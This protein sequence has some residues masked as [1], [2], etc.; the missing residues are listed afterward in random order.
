M[1]P[2]QVITIARNKLNAISDNFWSDEELYNYL[3]MKE[4]ELAQLANTIE[5]RYTADS[6]ASQIE[7][8]YPTNTISVY[9]VEYSSVKL[10]KIDQRQYDS[11][12]SD[13]STVVTG[14]PLYYYI[15]DRIIFLHPAP[16]TAITSAIRMYS[17]D[18]PNVHTA[19]S[20]FQTPLEY[21][22]ALI[23]GVAMEM[24]PKE[25]GHPN[26]LYFERIWEGEKQRV[27]RAE[28]TR[29][30]G[31]KFARVLREEDLITDQFGIV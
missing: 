23:S 4:S 17:Y 16:A 31:D 29:R 2:L 18:N 26:R 28:Q 25:L 7:Y 12:H 30:R 8:T 13:Q 3:F 11:I 15:Y 6:V 10:S 1:T 21:H 9:R 22:N 5:N 20:S 27:E 14:T 24:C 19:S